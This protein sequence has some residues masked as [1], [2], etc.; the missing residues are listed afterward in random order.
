MLHISVSLGL[1]SY[2]STVMTVDVTTVRVNGMIL[3]VACRTSEE[4]LLYIGAR[5]GYW[6]GDIKGLVDDIGK[7]FIA[8]RP[9]PPAS[10]HPSPPAPNPTLYPI[11]APPYTKS[12]HCSFG[13]MARR[14]CLP[15]FVA[16]LTLLHLLLPFALNLHSILFLPSLLPFMLH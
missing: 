7:L 6:R 16:A 8:P 13:P 1:W 2:V 15:Q 12:I 11:P 10:L 4:L 14:L 5:I 9:K 3:H